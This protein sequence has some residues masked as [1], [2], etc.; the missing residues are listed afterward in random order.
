[1]F[2]KIQKRESG[3]SFNT[4]DILKSIASPYYYVLPYKNEQAYAE[5][6]RVQDWCLNRNSSLYDILTFDSALELARKTT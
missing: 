6:Q 2:K 3:E 4:F 5:F 1:M